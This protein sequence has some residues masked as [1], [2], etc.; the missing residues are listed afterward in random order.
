M[1]KV[2]KDL[3]PVEYSE[4]EVRRWTESAV[5]NTHSFFANQEMIADKRLYDTFGE[6]KETHENWPEAKKLYPDDEYLIVIC[7]FKNYFDI[8][9][10]EQKAEL[11]RAA[12]GFDF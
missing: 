9:S 11:E 7:A 2:K 4:R 10:N 1:S 5:K 6:W 3:E 12:R 8:L